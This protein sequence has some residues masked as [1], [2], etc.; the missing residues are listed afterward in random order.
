MVALTGDPDPAAGR[1][2]WQTVLDEHAGITDQIRVDAAWARAAADYS[3]QA[4]RP[5]RLVTVTEA[6]SSAGRSRA[7]A[8]AQLARS[9]H[10]ATSNRVDAFAIGVESG[11]TADRR[12]AAELAAHLVT[13]TESGTLSGAELV[14]AA[15][16]LGLRSHPSPAT[17]ICF[18][19]P[20]VPDWLD[21]ALRDAMSG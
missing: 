12:A 5:L 2:G 10:I 20:E 1:T 13:G 4:D 18:G 7:Q 9:A 3:A 15:G 8:S 11:G 6:R 17:T 19:G 14:V 21:G 16:W